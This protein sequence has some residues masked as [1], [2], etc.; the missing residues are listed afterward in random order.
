MFSAPKC[1]KVI[2]PEFF[3]FSKRIYLNKLSPNLPLW[4]TAIPILLYKIKHLCLTTL[5]TLR[6]FIV[7]EDQGN[8][9]P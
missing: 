2:D 8:V 7:Q 1:L 4:G 5:F 3:L 6:K 9:G